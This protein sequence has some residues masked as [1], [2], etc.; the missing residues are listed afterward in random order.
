MLKLRSPLAPIALK[1]SLLQ[2]LRC[3]IKEKIKAIK[4]MD[5][6]NI[7]PLNP[8]TT[9]LDKDKI[10]DMDATL[11]FAIALI[12]LSLAGIYWVKF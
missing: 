7:S 8:S 9:H 5:A 6:N 12:G 3:S 4:V 2:Q 11:I 1:Y 10:G